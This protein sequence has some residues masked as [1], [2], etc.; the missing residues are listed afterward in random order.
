MDYPGRVFGAWG[1]FQVGSRFCFFSTSIHF[2]SATAF[3]TSFNLSSRTISKRMG[4]NKGVRIR[5]K[6]ICKSN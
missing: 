2:S 6:S 3:V 1:E 4:S 5:N